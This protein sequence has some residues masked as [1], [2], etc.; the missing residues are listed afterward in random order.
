M[1]IM[2]YFTKINMI[3]HVKAIKTSQISL[4][5]QENKTWKEPEHA[6]YYR[7]IPQGWALHFQAVWQW[8]VL[9]FYPNDSY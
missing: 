8:T 3:A 5:S 9:L 2:I 4:R 7:F 6:V 1:I